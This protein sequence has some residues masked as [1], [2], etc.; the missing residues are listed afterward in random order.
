MNA[1]HCNKY[2][3]TVQVHMY[4]NCFSMDRG[5]T[6]HL[7]K[8]Q[9]HYQQSKDDLCQK[10]KTTICFQCILTIQLWIN[11]SSFIWMNMDLVNPGMIC[12]T[13]KHYL[14]LLLLV[15]IFFLLNLF[16]QLCHSFYNKYWGW[17]KKIKFKKYTVITILWCVLLAIPKMSEQWSGTVPATLTFTW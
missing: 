17:R 16:Q 7:D 14:F 4:F 15:S 1:L 2:H 10:K 5:V 12:A 8:I 11:V 13:K 9:S 3:L 6:F